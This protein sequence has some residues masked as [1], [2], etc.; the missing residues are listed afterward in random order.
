MKPE[1]EP[2]RNKGVKGELGGTQKSEKRTKGH[3]IQKKGG[4]RKIKR[5]EQKVSGPRAEQQKWG[6]GGGGE[7]GPGKKGKKKGMEYTKQLHGEGRNGER[8]ENRVKR[9]EGDKRKDENLR[10]EVGN[11][12]HGNLQWRSI[13]KQG[14]R[15][16]HFKENQKGGEKRGVAKKKRWGKRGEKVTREDAKEDSDGEKRGNTEQ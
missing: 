2:V 5:E 7:K 3:R 12:T 14:K 8:L 6:R 11:Q 9:G 13:Q 4:R 1:K 15:G 16:G 10:K